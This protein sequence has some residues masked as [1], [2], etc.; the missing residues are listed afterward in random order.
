[1]RRPALVVALAV[2]AAFATAAPASAPQ[3]LPPAAIV[4][5][6]ANLA[7]PAPPPLPEAAPAVAY[8]APE[9]PPPAPPPPTT[10]VS[11]PPPVS[12]QKS[13]G[14][15]GG[16]EAMVARH[17]PPEQ[18][19]KGCAVMACET[20]NTFDPTIYN[21]SGSGASGL[22]QFLRSTWADVTGR[23]DNAADATPEEQTAAAGALWRSS[24]WSPWSCA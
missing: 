20:G 9:P 6:V 24:G 4:R 3:D 5:P 17:F 21:R 10:V 13:S 19:A 7:E 12:P 16:L 2:A 15:C 22:W 14:P 18:V 23:S 8:V 1:M 11:A